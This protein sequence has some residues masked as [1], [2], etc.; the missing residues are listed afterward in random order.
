LTKNTTSA[1]VALAWSGGKDSMLALHALRESGVPV[2]VLLT[3]VTEDFERISIHGVRRSLLEAQVEAVGVA[4]EIAPVPARCSNDEY[5]ASFGAAL[6]RLRERD[7]S[8]VAAGDLFLEDVR[9]YRE[10]L[11]SRFNMKAQFPL[12]GRDTALL[13]REFIESGFQA[14]LSCV[15]T[16]ALDA[17]FAGRA[18]DFDLLRDLPPNV[19]PCGENGEFHTFVWNGPTFKH[20]VSCVTGERVLRDERFAFCD[21]IAV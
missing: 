18:F 11:F 15:D 9:A 1:P 19:D 13:A 20:P 5:E 10:A 4:L 12:W 6:E 2:A 17:S 16:H 3:T 7:I 14:T 21:L 8:T